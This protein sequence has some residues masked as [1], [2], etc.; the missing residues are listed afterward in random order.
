MIQSFI[1]VNYKIFYI[2]IYI[3]YNTKP[4]NLK[5]CQITNKYMVVQFNDQSIMPIN[6]YD[7]YIVRP[8]LNCQCYFPQLTIRKGLLLSVYTKAAIA[9][10]VIELFALKI[11]HTSV[12]AL[13]SW[14]YPFTW[15]RRLGYISLHSQKKAS[16]GRFL[17][18]KEVALIK[19]CK[20]CPSTS[21]RP[22]RRSKH[23]QGWR[24]G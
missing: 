8:F 18:P 20:A 17:D 9:L 5:Y 22:P 7:I 21:T 4:A 23:P 2:Y 14:D 1:F 11:A 12:I 3:K 6:L 10:M 24:T 19:S 13:S 16:E 15:H